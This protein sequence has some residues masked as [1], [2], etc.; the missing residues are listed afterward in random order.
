MTETKIKADAET[1][2]RHIEA[3]AIRDRAEQFEANVTLYM[4]KRLGGDSM[5]ARA[6]KGGIIPLK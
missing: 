4:I 5:W 3:D 1:L 2:A 6:A